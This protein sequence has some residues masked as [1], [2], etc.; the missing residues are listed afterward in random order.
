MSMIGI[1]ETMVRTPVDFVD[2]YY[3]ATPDGSLE[4][5]EMHGIDFAEA[6]KAH[7]GDWVL[8]D[9]Y[10]MPTGPRA[11]KIVDKRDKFVFPK[12][13]AGESSV[14]AMVPMQEDR[15]RNVIGRVR[16]DPSHDGG[17]ISRNKSIGD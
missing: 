6:Q 16:A 3:L 2:A 7:P 5:Y 11:P 15:I 13:P 17:P 1:R 14:V 9:D 4:L 10:K 8:V 12:V